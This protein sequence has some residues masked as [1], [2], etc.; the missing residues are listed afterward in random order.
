MSNKAAPPVSGII[1][2]GGKSV[3]MGTD[4]A[5]LKL[6]PYY[7]IER[8]SLVLRTMVDEIIIVTD[9]PERY[10]KY[11]DSTTFDIWPGNGPMGGIHAGLVQ[12]SHSWAL[13]TACDLPFIS[14]SVGRLLMRCAADYDV[15]VPR[16][17]GYLES[18]YAMYNKSCIEIFEQHLTQGLVKINRLYEEFNTRYLE[19]EE[20]LAVEPHLE[21]VFFNLNTP[22][23]IIKAQTW[24]NEPLKLQ[25]D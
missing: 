23:D 18:L 12:C 5:L 13:V 10:A 6:G 11:G 1:L 16:Y 20:M 2:A 7:I 3:R 19:E 8:I 21:R 24:G 17:Q 14:T 15:V 22:E 25:L 9:R 4:K